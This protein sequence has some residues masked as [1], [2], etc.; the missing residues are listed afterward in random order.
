[1]TP[2]AETLCWLI[3]ATCGRTEVA[4]ANPCAQTQTILCAC[5]T[6]WCNAQLS[7]ETRGKFGRRVNYVTYARN[8]F[9]PLE[10]I[11]RREWETVV[12]ASE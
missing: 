7:C 5:E 11:E 12:E 3:L 1:M 4:W 8:V 2:F 6:G 9:S 10:P